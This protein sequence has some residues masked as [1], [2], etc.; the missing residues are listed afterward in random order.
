MS[1]L[2]QGVE[3]VVDS[4]RHKLAT[5]GA[6]FTVACVI[7]LGWWYADLNLISAQ[8]G[9]GYWL[10]IIG[11]VLMALLLIY[12]MRKRVRAMRS[13]GPVRYW[14][15]T[16]M[17]FGVVGPVLIVFH[18]NFNLGSLNSRV[19]LF[20]TIIVALSGIVGRYVYAKLHYGLYGRKATLT[21]LRTDLND[22]RNRESQIARLI[23]TLTEEL[24]VWE[25]KQ[26]NADTGVLGSFWH[27]ISIQL[28]A[29]WRYRKFAQMSQTLINQ[30]VDET[31]GLA[32]HG[33]RLKENTRNYIKRRISLLRKFA[34]YRVFER[35][36]SW[37]HIVHYPLFILLV[38]AAIVHVVAVHMY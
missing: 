5:A 21:S 33:D 26:L 2:Q 17:I 11:A 9:I 22:L 32:G 27:A 25:N 29:L 24:N 10:G 35:L 38:F 28:S 16:H 19:A 15:R 30:A 36:F 12:P 34:Q 1:A 20:C 3:D 14:F 23:P 4:K 8:E 37:W 13:W 18:S 31:P 7:W 6:Y